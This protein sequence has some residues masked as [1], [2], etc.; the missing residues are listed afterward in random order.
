MNIAARVEGLAEGG[1]IC[2]SGTVFDQIKGKVSVN[3]EDLGPQ[4][5]KN[6]AERIR[7][8]RAVLSSGTVSAEPQKKVEVPRQDLRETSNIYNTL[9]TR[10]S[11]VLYS[12]IDDV[13]RRWK[14][15]L[16]PDRDLNFSA[17]VLSGG[18]IR[19]VCSTLSQG[20]S[21]RSL[22]PK[23]GERLRGYFAEAKIAGFTQASIN[24]NSANR[25]VFDRFGRQIGEMPVSRNP[26]SAD[27]WVY[28]RPIFERSTTTLD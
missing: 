27:K 7:A 23:M 15:S 16:K 2:I 1:G 26:G 20:H 9:M 5:V 25:P 22:T 14:T 24:I 10:L 3:F 28:A 8:Y 11:P 13:M 4:Q 21:V 17:S 12:G 19:T 6:I 18:F